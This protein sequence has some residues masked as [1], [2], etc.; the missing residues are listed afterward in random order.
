MG[1][2]N[3]INEGKLYGIIPSR[4]GSTRFPGKP[5]CMIGGKAM[6]EHVY[7]RVLNSGYFER[8]LVATD[9]SRIYDY[10]NGFGGEAIMTDA[11]H[12][13]GSER[14]EE[15]SQLL[16]LKDEDILINIQGDEPFI[17]GIHISLVAESFKD[18]SVTI[19]TLA[20][21]IEREEELWDPNVVKVLVNV[22][23]YAIYFSRQTI[24]YQRNCELKEWFR[25]G[26]Y[27]KHIGLYGYKVGILKKL[28]RLRMSNLEKMEGLEQ[29]RWL[30]NG[31]MIKVVET[32]KET[33]SV[34]TPED[35]ERINKYYEGNK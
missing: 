17:E 1:D 32:D 24:P 34:D 15:V 31:Y 11:G 16:K 3:I 8:V 27:Y 5:L 2:K 21:R 29:L 7:E 33:L 19:S 10:V 23:G 25:Q 18:R 12:N 4:Y 28:V 30:E 9:D 14:C 22:L 6:V 20:K 35:L 26:S 13:S